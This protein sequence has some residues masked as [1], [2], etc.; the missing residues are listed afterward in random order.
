MSLL[1]LA[2]LHLQRF[3]PCIEIS[4]QMEVLRM[5]LNREQHTRVVM[6]HATTEAALLDLDAEIRRLE[7]GNGLQAV[8]G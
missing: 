2:F 8:G 3:S 5:P 4:G 6:A 7:R 1:K